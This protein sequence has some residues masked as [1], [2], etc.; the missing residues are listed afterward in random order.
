MPARR[1]CGGLVTPP[2]MMFGAQNKEVA[3]GIGHCIL[4]LQL[5]VSSQ[6]IVGLAQLAQFQAPSHCLIDRVSRVCNSA[7]V[8]VFLEMYYCTY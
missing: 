3:L 2:W 6:P 4:G 8:A 1:R 5:D 7:H